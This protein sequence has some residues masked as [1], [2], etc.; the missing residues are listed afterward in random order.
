[1][2]P[3][4]A[5]CGRLAR[6]PRPPPARYC[7]KTSDPTCPPPPPRP[8]PRCDER[9]LSRTLTNDQS[10]RFDQ[11]FDFVMV[12][13]G[14]RRGPGKGGGLEVGRGVA[15][16]EGAGGGHSG[17][18]AHGRDR[19]FV[20]SRRRPGAPRLSPPPAGSMLTVNVW[21]KTSALEMAA[22][23]KLTKVGA[24]G[25]PPGPWGW[26][27]APPGPPRRRGGG[28]AAVPP[29]LRPAPHPTPARTPPSPS[30]PH[31]TPTPHPQARFQDRLIGRVTIPVADVVRN[32][33][34]RDSF[35]LQDA[36]SGTI[37]M[38][39]EWANCFVD[40]FID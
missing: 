5:A 9:K 8:L 17:V 12:S 14:E 30:T 16:L 11:K 36:E 40:E 21:D 28:R 7:L 20:F 24:A 34:L 6:L 37:E 39:L 31:R 35:A 27:R 32:G 18:G 19:G 3:R 15:W 4:P 22:S 38:K 2:A 33:R 23:F 13:A 26:G 1:V 29:A 10:P 25:A